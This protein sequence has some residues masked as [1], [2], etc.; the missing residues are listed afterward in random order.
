MINKIVLWTL[1]CAVALPCAAQKNPLK[2]LSFWRKS[3]RTVF[4]QPAPSFRSVQGKILPSPARP[5]VPAWQR[6]VEHY[7]ARTVRMSDLTNLPYATTPRTARQRLAF[8]AKY[9]ETMA[10][11]KKF[12]SETDSFLYYQ[13]KPS[14]K[15]TLH[16]AESNMRLYSIMDMER[17]L[18]RL[19]VIVDAKADPALAFA[20]QYVRRVRDEV[21][22]FLKGL[23]GEDIYFSRSDRKFVPREFYLHT[24]ELGGLIGMLRPG[25]AVKELQQLPPNLR[26]AVLNDRRSVL[27]KVK[28]SHKKGVFIATG[29]VSCFSRADD[30]L[31]SVH[32]GVKYDVVLT[33]MVVA[34]GGGYYLTNLLR[35][36][37]F[38]GA[39]IAVTA[40]EPDDQMALDMFNRGFDGMFTMAGNFEYFPLWEAEIMRGLNK[41]F[42]LRQ[43]RGWVR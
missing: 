1:L 7:I 15:R 41:Y 19:S 30:L 5:S 28:A 4:E 20:L 40:Y 27:D 29:Q 23:S 33:D 32:S 43:M 36:N 11:F 6:D 17:E 42:R 13:L 9:Q 25:L 38:R 12:K 37:G 21:S 10:R 16:S 39:V 14:E 2:W 35:L 31:R 22:P 3:S 8:S 24:F 26:V 34:G 18:V